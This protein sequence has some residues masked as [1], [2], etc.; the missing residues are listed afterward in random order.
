MIAALILAAA[1]A[2]VIPSTWQ[3]VDVPNPPG[4]T[5]EVLS[6]AR[7]P[8]VSGFTT[9]INVIRKR[10]SDDAMLIGDWAAA[11]TNDLQSHDG[12]K[13]VTSHKQI[14][15]DI[16]GWVVESTGTYDGRDLDLIQEAILDG[17]YEYVATYSRPVGSAADADALKALATLCPL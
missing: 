10:Y 12:V 9:T 5:V 11:A 16:N 8:V 1:T 6:L 14:F 15:C 7:G 4:S 17:G 2:L 3:A 13:I